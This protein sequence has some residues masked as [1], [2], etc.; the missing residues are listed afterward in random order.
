MLKG[1]LLPSVL[2]T[3]HWMT[4]SETGMSQVDQE[5]FQLTTCFRIRVQLNIFWWPWIPWLWSKLLGSNSFLWMALGNFL[6]IHFGHAIRFTVITVWLAWIICV[7]LV[8]VRIYVHHIIT[9][10]TIV[11]SLP[12]DS[13][14]PHVVIIAMLKKVYNSLVRDGKWKW[15]AIHE[16]G[17]LWPLSDESLVL[18]SS[19]SGIVINSELSVLGNMLDDE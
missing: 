15:C 18:S 14:L 7:W 9:I 16:D 13:N 8:W 1:I 6:G 19:I 4:K 17:W 3:L 5:Q 12:F 10:T 11:C 2:T